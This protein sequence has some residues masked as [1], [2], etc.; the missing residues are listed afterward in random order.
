MWISIWWI[1]IH[2]FCSYQL[3]GLNKLKLFWRCTRCAKTVN[4]QMDD[5]SKLKDYI[6]GYD[7]EQSFP[8]VVRPKQIWCGCVV[9]RL[10]LDCIA[11]IWHRKQQHGTPRLYISWNWNGVAP[12]TAG[13]PCDE[14][15]AHRPSSTNGAST[16]DSGEKGGKSGVW[17][18]WQRSFEVWNSIILVHLPTHVF[19]KKSQQNLGNICLKVLWWAI[20]IGKARVNKSTYYLNSGSSKKRMICEHGVWCRHHRLVLGRGQAMTLHAGMMWW[21]TYNILRDQQWSLKLQNPKPY[22]YIYRFD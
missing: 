7:H 6:Y 8:L 22:I 1:R 19:L 4:L 14:Q 13:R 2:G 9:V 18:S 5:S 11:M 16:C 20:L 3:L 17:M 12:Q 21:T 15:P 10:P